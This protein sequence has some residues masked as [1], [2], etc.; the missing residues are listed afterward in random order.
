MTQFSPDGQTFGAS[1]ASSLAAGQALSSWYGQK[2]A[3]VTGVH[4]PDQAPPRIPPGQALGPNAVV[5][6]TGLNEGLKGDLPV[7]YAHSVELQ[8]ALPVGTLIPQNVRPPQNKVAAGKPGIS[9]Q[10]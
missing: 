5:A 10:E 1:P 7:V 4:V 9:R 6:P 3:G 8:E 2:Q